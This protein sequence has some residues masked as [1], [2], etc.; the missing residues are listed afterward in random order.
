MEPQRT[1]YSGTLKFAAGNPARLHIRQ[2]PNSKP[3]KQLKAF[4]AVPFP[5][6]RNKKIL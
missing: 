6:I 4:C 2:P 3:G 5:L 1:A